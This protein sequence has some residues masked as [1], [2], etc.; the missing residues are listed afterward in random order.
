MFGKGLEGGERVTYDEEVAF[1][2]E[3]G[4]SEVRYHE[5]VHTNA[6]QFG[7]IA[8]AVVLAGLE[9]EEE[10]LIGLVHLA[11]VVAQAGDVGP[12]IMDDAL[13]RVDYMGNIGNRHFQ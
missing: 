1:R 3:V 5:V 9:G 8:V 4:G 7:D 11:A 6:G 12:V 2:V 13:Q 10:G